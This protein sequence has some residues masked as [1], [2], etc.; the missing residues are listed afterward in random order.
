MTLTRRTRAS[1]RQL[2]HQV[3]RRAG[4]ELVAAE[5][6]FLTV[7]DDVDDDYQLWAHH[8]DGGRLLEAARIL[9]IGFLARPLPGVRL[10]FLDWK[11]R[12]EDEL[13]AR[14][15]SAARV[16]WTLARDSESWDVGKG[17]GGSPLSVA[18]QREA[19]SRARNRGAR[20]VR[21]P[22]GRRGGLCRLRTT[23]RWTGVERPSRVTDGES[24]RDGSNPRVFA[25]NDRSALRWKR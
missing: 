8:L 7:V 19:E 4:R 13:R 12:F 15:Q 21:K 16:A 3:T 24:S 14:L 9:G 10:E 1:I 20:E 17:R 5:G 23:A 2:R 18:G 22:P 6:D 11:E 25:G